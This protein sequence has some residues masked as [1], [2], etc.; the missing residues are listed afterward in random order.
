MAKSATILVKFNGQREDVLI[1]DVN[2]LRVQKIA[3]EQWDKNE[4]VKAVITCMGDSGLLSSWG[5]MTSDGTWI[6]P[7]MNDMRDFGLD[8]GVRDDIFGD[9]AYFGDDEDDDGDIFGDDDEEYEGDEDDEEEDDD[10]FGDDD[11]DE[12]DWAEDDE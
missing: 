6:Q 4:D 9:D 2:G 1:E 5:M 3:H 7:E 10:F 11:E 12:D 8:E